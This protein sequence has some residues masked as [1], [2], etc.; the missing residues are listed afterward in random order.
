[1]P[2]T[3]EAPVGAD[4]T[5]SGSEDGGV[6][7]G[8]VLATDANGDA[9]TYALVGEA[10]DGV[11]FNSDGSY[12]VTPQPSDQ[13]LGSGESRQVVFQYT[14]SDGVETSA[15]ATVTVTIEGIND[16]PELSVV[17]PEQRPVIVSNSNAVVLGM[18]MLLTVL[19]ADG[20]LSQLNVTIGSYT[21]GDVL[22]V[23][24]GSTGIIATFDPET[25]VLALSGT[26]GV[27]DYQSV[28]Q[29]L[30]L[31]TT[32]E[33]GEATRLIDVS[34]GDGQAVSNISFT[35]DV[36]YPV[37]IGTDGDDVLTGTSAADE[38]FGFDGNDTLNGLDG[39]DFLIGGEGNDLLIGGAGDDSYMVDAAGDVVLEETGQGT[40]TVVASVNWTLGSE[41]ENLALIGMAVSG[42][43]NALDNIMIGNEADNILKGGLGNDTLDG[44]IGTDTLIGGAGDDIY[45][46]AASDQADDI[47][48]EQSFGGIDVVLAE[49]S[50]VLGSNVEDLVLIGSD[51]YN[52]SGNSLANLIVGNSGDNVLAGGGGSDMLI[53]G[54]GNDTYILTAGDSLDLLVE[55]AGEGS[56]DIVRS[57]ATWT[58]GNN[59]ENLTLTGLGNISGSGNAEANLLTGNGGNNTLNGLDGDDMLLGNGGADKLNGGNGNDTLNG[60][61]GIDRLSGGDGDDFYVVTAGDVVTEDLGMGI[62]TVASSASFTLAANVEHLQLTG[63][64]TTGTG[65]DLDNVLTGN[66]AANKL[67]GAAGN[68]TLIGGRG[69]DT[70]LGGIGNDTYVLN[71]GDGR[72]VINEN[73]ATVDDFDV[74]RF[75][76][77]IDAIN[78]DQLW[79][80]KSDQNLVVSVIG[81]SDRFTVSGW[82][83]GEARQ[84]ETFTTSD[85]YALDQAQVQSLV[86]AMAAFA[87]PPAGITALDT[88]A[89]GTVLDQIAA[90]WT[91]Q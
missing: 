25:G 2:I 19:D 1:M 67:V 32:A 23:D 30:S 34:V 28:L 88:G 57:A 11:I 50:Y 89:Y 20:E 86:N 90:S 81:S 61:G 29:T 17:E 77:S 54:D 79:F 74:A 5:N 68:D 66:N 91:A 72:D 3:N 59:F 12:S 69:N 47:I 38:L 62:D 64:A 87:P 15:P 78:H 44:G 41:A 84:V 8:S 63:I 60:G 56:L 13:A 40:D 58:L 73:D 4:A 75:G 7:M 52:G 27:Q 42:T 71:R 85:G 24:T 76:T 21:V 31:A 36:N 80:Q 33:S 65:N 51:H 46:L 18:S 6:I 70:L 16:A 39:D 22:S 53:G 35:V 55:V 82:F 14:A 9:L 26:A 10:P 43:G 45:I 37:L 48:K 49:R 83:A